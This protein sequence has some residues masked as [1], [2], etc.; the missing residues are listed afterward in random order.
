MTSPSWTDPGRLDW[1]DDVLARSGT[2]RTGPPEVVH[3]WALS[4]VERV[5]TTA[6]D[7]YVKASCEHFAAE[8]ALTGWL[9][10]RFPGLVP[11]VL[12]VDPARRCMLM[13]PLPGGEVGA[14]TLPAAA[15]TLGRLHTGC[16]GHVDELLRLGAPH[17]SLADTARRFQEVAQDA[18]ELPRSP[19]EQRRA[20]AA[21]VPWALDRVAELDAV[22]LPDTLA[23]GDLHLGN[24]APDGASAVVY[25]WSDVHVGH[26]LLDVTH[27][28]AQAD[29]LT[30]EIP[31]GW[32]DRYLEAWR[33]G[34]DDAVLHRAIE[35][36][37][38]VDRVFQAVTYEDL[39]RFLVPEDRR[40]LDGVQNRLLA[41][42]VDL[43]AR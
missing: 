26:P 2:L 38:P 43:A 30:G 16:L 8:P 27:L 34:W 37:V 41:Q 9:S 6:G 15:A 17:R 20:L 7:R 40:A 19:P 10:G 12:A 3:S 5:P 24:V 29:E 42:V 22:G 28:V 23:H 4:H 1:V 21:A 25:D 18:V 39:L 13:A 36:A 31:V 35:L 14:G 33:P 11:D 32:S